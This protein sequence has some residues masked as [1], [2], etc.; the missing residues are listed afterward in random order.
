M[1]RVCCDSRTY[2]ID[3]KLPGLNEYT[4]SCRTNK[5]SGARVKRDA[6]ALI[7]PQLRDRRPFPTPCTVHIDWFEADARRDVD[8]VEFGQKF[9]LDSLVAVGIIPDDSRRHVT[10][11]THG[12]DIDRKHPRIVVTLSHYRGDAS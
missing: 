6:H 3:G 4:R 10:L 7:T 12:I 5:Y 2:T 9:I 11:T 1:M 8:N